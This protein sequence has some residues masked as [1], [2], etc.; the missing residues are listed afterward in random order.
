M[1]H[2]K[3]ILIGF[4]LMLMAISASAQINPMDAQFF[5]NP[6][7]ANPAKAG[8]LAAARLN[9]AYRNQWSSMPGSPRSQMISYD[10]QA[11]KVGLGL[12]VN[13]DRAGL[14]DFT[15]VMGT[16][17]YH[18]PLNG[19]KRYLDFGLSLGFYKRNFGLDR[20]IGDPNDQ[21]LLNYDT[22]P[23][24]EGD[25]GIAYS[26]PKFGA[27][28]ALY[29]LKGQFKGDFKNSA[30]NQL[31]YIATDYLFEVSDWSVKSKLAY[32]VVRNYTNIVDFGFNATSADEKLDFTTIYHSSKSMSFGIGYLHNKKWH[33]LGVYNTPNTAIK[34]YVNGTF[35]V[36]L[37]LNLQKK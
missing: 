23:M 10:T 31:A 27:E 1:K 37:S 32:R 5:K 12:S 4:S 20:V 30:D 18:V 2:T 14:L 6:Y 9:I 7:L 21:S 17:A 24:F 28:V 26:S 19:D 13:T 25:A 29:N 35:E 36:A 33:I 22:K 15:K 11:N 3:N 34:G 16:Y 8:A